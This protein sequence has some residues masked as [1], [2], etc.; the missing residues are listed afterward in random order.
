MSACG[1]GCVCA[2]GLRTHV[3]TCAPACT[4]ECVCLSVTECFLLQMCYM[5][6]QFA[7]VCLTHLTEGQRISW[8]FIGSH[9]CVPCAA[10]SHLHTYLYNGLH[11]AV[12]PCHPHRPS[13]ATVSLALLSFPPT[14]H[15]GPLSPCRCFHVLRA[16][17]SL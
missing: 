3:C 1:C 9:S 5:C 2:C 7:S 15:A 10:D 13:L 17:H 4:R 6:N 8:Q 14:P 12:D 11:F 16:P